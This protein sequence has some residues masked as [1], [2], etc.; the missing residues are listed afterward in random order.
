MISMPSG[1]YKNSLG[2]NEDYLES[3]T[4]P[5][6]VTT[7]PEFLLYLCKNVSEFN[8]NWENITSIGSY[9]FNDCSSLVI[10]ELS[11]PS[12][13]TLGSRTFG[14]VKIGRITDL[15]NITTTPSGNYSNFLFCDA[16][17]LKSVVFPETITSFEEDVLRN[18]TKIEYIIIKATTPPT[19]G[20]SPFASNYPIYVPDA[21]VTAYREASGWS[22]YADRIYP[23]S[24]YGV[25]REYEDITSNYTLEVGQAYGNVGGSI[26]FTD[27]T[28]YQHTKAAI[29]DVSYVVV[30]APSQA[31]SLVQYVD[32]N[33]KILQ[34]AVTNFPSI[35]TRY[36][37]G[38]VEGATHVYITSATG[39]M[40]IWREV[41]DNA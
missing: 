9:A 28:A 29:S 16:E 34:I 1:N 19:L 22:A 21:S 40:Q 12:L 39:T 3:F 11:M 37:I 5:A 17:Y 4:L 25:V 2:I 7:I 36:N 18:N 27:D 10:E 41:K 6:T 14:K 32:G 35:L 24:E 13:T 33:D 26:Q 8:V 20:R 31:S 30:K 23:I 38:S 15:G